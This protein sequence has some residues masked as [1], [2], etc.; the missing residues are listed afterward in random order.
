MQILVVCLGNICRSPLGEGIL[1]H[2]ARV[3]GLNWVV[4]SAGT[5]GWH[6]GE[7]P[8]HRSIKVARKYA[9]DITDQRARQLHVQDFERFDLILVMDRSNLKDV[10]RMA[11]HGAAR[12]K[13][14][15]FLEYAHGHAGEVPDPYYDDSAF[16]PVFQ[17][18]ESACDA[19][20]AR[21]VPE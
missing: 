10:Q 8:D 9:I 14:H 15:L 12:E 19:I 18:L 7:L 11:P 2:K 5:G 4:D 6:A 17:M 20:I 1:K 3:R 13:V 16:E 21:T